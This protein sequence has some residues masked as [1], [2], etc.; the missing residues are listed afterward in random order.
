MISPELQKAKDN[1]YSIE[2]MAGHE[3]EGRRTEYI[4]QI[5]HGSYIHLYY[6]DEAGDYWYKTKIRLPDDSI[7]DPEEAIF[8][9]SKGRRKRQWCP[10]DYP[11][12]QTPDACSAEAG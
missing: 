2:N 7:V 6:K 10:E 9:K 1:A 12:D 4:G 8:G 3:A 11:A 5:D